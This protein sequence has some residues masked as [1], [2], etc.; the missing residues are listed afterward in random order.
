MPALGGD[1]PPHPKIAEI[2]MTKQEMLGMAQKIR[3]QRSEKVDKVEKC[4][5]R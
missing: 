4:E 3:Q 5:P 2:F 1:Q